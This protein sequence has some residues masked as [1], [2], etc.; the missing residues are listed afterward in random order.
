M[1]FDWRDMRRVPNIGFT[2]EVR[3]TRLEKAIFSTADQSGANRIF[4]NVLPFRI[5]I[6]VAAQLRIPEIALPDWMFS[7]AWPIL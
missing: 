6:L 2:T 3:S 5:V 4:Y 1:T 7:Q